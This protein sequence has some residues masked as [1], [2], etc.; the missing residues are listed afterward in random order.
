MHRRLLTAAVLTATVVVLGVPEPAQASTDLPRPDH[1]VIVVEENHSFRQAGAQPYL[2]SLARSGA[3]MTASYGVTHPSQPNYLALWSGSTHGVRS[4]SCPHD[5]GRAASL[6]GQLRTVGRSA[7]AYA[8]SLPRTGFTGCRSGAYV[9]KHN[10]LADFA[11]TA[12]ASSIRG[13][14]S[15]P[16]GHYEDLPSVSLVIPDLRNDM[17]DGSV[18]RGDRWLK[19]HLSG[20]AAWAR[21]HNSLLVVTFD[22][23]DDSS[24]NHVMTVLAGEHVRA[25]VRSSQR[26]SH[27][28]L[29]HTIERAYGLKQL[30]RPAR[31]ITG[32]WR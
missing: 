11:A 4:D 10:P 26:I 1:V 12:N 17:H 14:R 28:N 27:V 16:T 13:L 6:G 30:G 19:R 29:L 3:V 9:R 24:R 18:A 7:R 25:G 22:E 32:I 2:A 20:Y 31:P 23:D 5:L 21:T 15:W 8:E